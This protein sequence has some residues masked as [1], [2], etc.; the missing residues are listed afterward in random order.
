MKHLALALLLGLATLTGASAQNRV[1]DNVVIGGTSQAKAGSTLSL[2][3]TT[4]LGVP[5]PTPSAPGSGNAIYSDNLGRVILRNSAGTQTLNL[6]AGST[7]T[8]NPSVT[9]SFGGNFT[10][11]GSSALTLTTTGSTNVT[12][13]TS[14]TLATLAGSETF[15]NKTLTAP[16]I[17][18][19]TLSGT[20]AGGGSAVFSNL[21]DVRIGT[22]TRGYSD[23]YSASG[24]H[25]QTA[26][27]TVTGNIYASAASGSEHV[28]INNW[29]GNNTAAFQ[30][31]N[32]GGFSAV[33]LL[34]NNGD[35]VGAVTYG[36]MVG[37]SFG[38]VVA[39][40]ASNFVKADGSN[41]YGNVPP[42]KLI[43][44][45]LITSSGSTGNSWI[46]LEAQGTTGNLLFYDHNQSNATTAMNKSTGFWGFGY[47]AG[48]GSGNPKAQVDV[49]GK[50]AAGDGD[51]ATDATT[52]FL[53]VFATDGKV[54]RFVRPSVVKI[55]MQ[56]NG[57]GSTR[58]FDFVDTDN[59][60]VVPLSLSLNGSGNVAVAGALTVGGGTALAKI[61]SASAS[62]DYS[63]I[64]A[65][66]EATL[67]ITVTGAVTTNT[68]TVA[69]GW[70]AA[71]PDGIVV[72]QA[73]VSAA[74]TVSV[75]V[76]NVTAGSIDPSAVTCRAT[77]T[78]F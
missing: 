51:R 70:S 35:E 29:S 30:N 14:G 73:W 16:T 49:A 44:T 19:A 67:T 68:P 42:L 75:R 33:R 24:S 10:T 46:A 50:I 27:L 34:D 25:T 11:S 56:I 26:A 78:N 23:G 2:N 6:G 47:N 21:G 62:L 41:V 71:L 15:T 69:L 18:A 22:S 54:A 53:N 63:S 48:F 40:E 8:L 57:S 38:H 58:R 4:I 3:G 64:S 32:A 74:D 76:A 52:Y 31:L 59:S 55:D 39:L 17:N 5:S 13:P 60:S 20:L 7:L 43:Q 1:L 65:G 28:F 66:A 61:V 77:V 45:G 36:N 12:L 72:K 9:A 37:G